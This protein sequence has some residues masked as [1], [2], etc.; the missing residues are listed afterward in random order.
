[1]TTEPEPGFN[2]RLLRRFI[3]IALHYAR[4]EERWRAAALLALLVVLLLGRLHTFSSTLDQEAARHAL[5]T[6]S[7]RTP[8]PVIQTVHGTELA[9]EQLTV[10]TPQREHL[11]ILEL[12]L[13]VNPGEGLLIV[14]PSG[15]G[16]RSCCW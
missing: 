2:A 9:V 14:G 5:E 6:S 12:S 10:F 4:S 16:K 7:T 13:A 3:A 8:I 15:G 1:M 11:L